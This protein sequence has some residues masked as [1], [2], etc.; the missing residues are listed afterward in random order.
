M[1]ERKGEGTKGD[2]EQ[3][4]VLQESNLCVALVAVKGLLRRISTLDKVPSSEVTGNILASTWSG[5]LVSSSLNLGQASFDVDFPYGVH[6]GG[7][8]RLDALMNHSSFGV[9]SPPRNTSEEM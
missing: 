8:H 6:V 9:Q 4:L 7:P 3:I 5:D 2:D 1:E